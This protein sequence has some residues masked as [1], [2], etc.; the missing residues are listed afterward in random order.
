MF[1]KK[2]ADSGKVGGCDNADIVCHKLIVMTRVAGG[3]PA[4]AGLFWNHCRVVIRSQDLH[5]DTRLPWTKYPSA[6][7]N[8][9]KR[10]NNRHLMCTHI[11]RIPYPPISSIKPL[12]TVKLYLRKKLCSQKQNLK[13][14]LFTNLLCTDSAAPTVLKAKYP[15]SRATLKA[16]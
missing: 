14:Y 4:V 5:T 7:V 1:Y 10:G 6:D 8:V 16:K 2:A 3:T 15:K 12:C 11:F 9:L 13:C